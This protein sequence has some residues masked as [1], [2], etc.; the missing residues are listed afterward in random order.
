[1][2]FPVNHPVFA[3]GPVGV[4]PL[5]AH[6]AADVLEG[7]ASLQAELPLQDVDDLG[8]DPDLLEVRCVA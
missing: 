4:C 1:M 5:D 7:D 6:V 2:I 3:L 8:G